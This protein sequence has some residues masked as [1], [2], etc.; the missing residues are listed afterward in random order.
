MSMS[1][2]GSDKPLSADEA[3]QVTLLVNAEMTSSIL[4]DRNQW[5]EGVIGKRRRNL[6]KRL[7]SLI[8]EINQ[9][10]KGRLPDNF[11]KRAEVFYLGVEAGMNTLLKGYKSM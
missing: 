10:Y 7:D 8:E 9:T 3:F 6:L 1:H 4:R 2:T 11:I 5:T